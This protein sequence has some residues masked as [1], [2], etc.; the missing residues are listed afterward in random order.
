MFRQESCYW[1]PMEVSSHDTGS[2]SFLTSSLN[3]KPKSKKVARSC[4]KEGLQ[5]ICTPAL[6]HAP[7]PMSGFK[8]WPVTTVR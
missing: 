7:L 6:S 5:S 3:G 4:R 2:T 8:R 1:L